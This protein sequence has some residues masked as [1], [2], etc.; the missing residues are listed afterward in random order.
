MRPVEFEVTE[1][2][3]S[4]T[5]DP[6]QGGTTYAHVIPEMI[7]EVLG[8]HQSSRERRESGRR[9]R[10][11]GPCGCSRLEGWPGEGR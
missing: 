11:T 7:V 10:R 2:Q 8:M 1:G 5:G 3:A 6:C 9:M 4:G